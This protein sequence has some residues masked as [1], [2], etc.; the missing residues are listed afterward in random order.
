LVVLI[1]EDELLIGAMMAEVISDAGFEVVEA[2]NAD[3]GLRIL[4]GH[5]GIRVVLTDIDMPGS[6]DGLELA[7]AIRHRW[8]GIEIIVT[9]GKWRP[10]A[11]EYAVISWRSHIRLPS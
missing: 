4:E 5:P 7:C 10:Y 1:V 9:S 6:M 2:P 8:P 3:E 11:D